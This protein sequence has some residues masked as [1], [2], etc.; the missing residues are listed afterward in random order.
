MKEIHEY[1]MKEQKIPFT[2]S[3]KTLKNV[4]KT[5]K[6]V[7]TYNELEVGGKKDIFCF[8]EIMIGMIMLIT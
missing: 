7:V 8:P 4:N 3:Y 1:K 5:K 2:I 6:S